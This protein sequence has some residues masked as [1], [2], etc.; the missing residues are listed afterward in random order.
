[1][2]HYPGLE[3]DTM[4]IPE[5]L[6][7]AGAFRST[8][9]DLLKYLSANLGFLHT[10]LDD[11]IQLQHLIQYPCKTVNSIN[12]S[13]YIALGWR[14]LTNFGSETLT[15]IGVLPGWNAFVGFTP[16][17]KIGV[18]LLC[19]CDSNDVDMEKLGFVL[20]NLLELQNFIE[21]KEK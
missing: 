5:I 20:L 16:V 10:V 12:F 7:G 19:S 13:E 8:V 1:M 15:H 3:T 4:E 11:A 9:N 17:K 21:Q 2:G 18:V 6:A 14:V